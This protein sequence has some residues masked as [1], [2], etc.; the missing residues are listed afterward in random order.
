M[1]MAQENSGVKEN[2]RWIWTLGKGREL[3]GREGERGLTCGVNKRCVS[4]ELA[5]MVDSKGT[6]S[7]GRYKRIAVKRRR[8]CVG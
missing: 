5:V 7:K 6:T 8:M 1:G 3:V 4:Y 2:R